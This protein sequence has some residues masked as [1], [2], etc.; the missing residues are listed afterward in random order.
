MDNFMRCR[1]NRRQEKLPFQ[2]YKIDECLNLVL[3]I[4]GNTGRIVAA[5]Q[6]G[7]LEIEMIVGKIAGI[8]QPP[9]QKG[10]N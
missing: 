2:R 10:E 9:A 3:R 5:L 4:I 8:R 6:V 7:F 1:C